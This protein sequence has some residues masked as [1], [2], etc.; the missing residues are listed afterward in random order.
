MNSETKTYIGADV[1]QAT[2]AFSGPCKAA[3]A[4]TVPALKAHLRTLPRPAH[5]ICEASGRHH[6]TLA[7]ACAKTKIPLTIL[8][9]AQARHH[10]RSHGQL[11]KTDPVDAEHLRLFGEERHPSQTTPRTASRQN[12]LDMC[13]VRSAIAEDIARHRTQNRQLSAPARRLFEQLIKRLKKELAKVEARLSD[14]LEKADETTQTRVHTMTLV[15]GIGTLSALQLEAHMPE[16]GKLNRRQAGKLAGL[17]P[18]ADQSGRKDAPRHIQGGRAQV[19]RVLYPCAVVAAR[20]NEELQA[21]DQK[22]KE[23]KKPA[24]QRYTAIAHKLLTYVNAMLREP[25]G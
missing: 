20:W 24:K 12:L 22:L 2:V 1:A 5:V 13:L 10:A 11:E 25:S 19:R 21:Y 17:A 3:I 15:K 9:P 4:N 6:H 7:K 16:L 8:N 18:L 14:W 23:A